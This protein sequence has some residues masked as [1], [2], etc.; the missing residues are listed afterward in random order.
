MAGDRAVVLFSGGLDSLAC[1]VWAK[2]TFPHVMA[3]FVDYSGRYQQRE[4]L[5]AQQLCHKLHVP[6]I[7]RKIK[8]V[9][10]EEDGHLPL[11]N[12]FLLQLASYH[13]DDIVFG[14]LKNEGSPDKTVGF[15]KKFQ[16]MLREQHHGREILI[17]TPC[18]NQTK[19]DILFDLYLLGYHQEINLTLGCLSVNN[20]CGRCYSC[21]NRWVAFRSLEEISTGDVVTPVY[22][23][24]PM[25][26]QLRNTATRNKN[27]DFGLFKKWAQ[28]EEFFWILR[29]TEKRFAGILWDLFCKRV[30]IEVLE[31]EKEHVL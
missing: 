1:L 27:R 29:R 13:A 14:A 4:F 6:L 18:I 28:L 8:L 22:A 7:T 23:Y 26:W 21:Y 9:P 24:S 3:L 30:P 25:Y 10:E 2:D 20:N 5:A 11:R 19:R 16:K 12:L 31:Y 17:H 15:L